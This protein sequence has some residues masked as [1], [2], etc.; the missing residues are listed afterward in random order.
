MLSRNTIGNRLIASIG[1]M[2]F[3]TVSVSLIAVVNWETLDTQIKTIVENNIPTLRASYQLERN[4]AVDLVG[5]G[6]WGLQYKVKQSK[7][8]LT[9]IERAG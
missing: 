7:Q 8:V 2:T 6:T 1:F 5:C 4:T 3:L 9:S